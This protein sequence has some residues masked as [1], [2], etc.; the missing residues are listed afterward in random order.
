MIDRSFD[1]LY[2]QS[3]GFEN[4][5]IIFIDDCSTDNSREKIQYYSEKYENVIGIYLNENSGYA[6]KPRNEGLKC[7]T[8]EYVMFLD[9]DD[10]YLEDAC[11]T[12]YEKISSE[13]V[14]LAS[15]NFC[16][17]NESNIHS[18]NHLD[19]KDEIKINDITEKPSLLLLPP[20][21]WTKIYKRKFILENGISF[22][23][24]LPGQDALFLYD[25]FIHADGI[26]FINKALVVYC[27]RDYTQTKEK[28]ITDDRTYKRLYDYLIVYE[29]MYNI[30]NDFNEEMV[31]AVSS[32]FSYWSNL[33]KNSRIPSQEKI[34]LIHAF[35]IL[36]KKV[37]SN[38]SA[39][40]ELM[41]LLTPI[42]MTTITNILDIEN[43]DLE[44]KIL[45]DFDRIQTY[46]QKIIELNN[47][48]Y[49][50]KKKTQSTQ[51]EE[52]I[53]LEDSTNTLKDKIN[54]FKRNIF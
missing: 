23:E 39:D 37:N 1:S 3:I 17:D 4:L 52:E 16:L 2:N 40:N 35:R 10:Y 18:W 38:L 5:E 9:S 27:K 49:I 7:A 25:V 15:G 24:N 14:D 48:L 46:Q 33:L 11:E 41:T 31:I 44:N 8:S 53:A 21:I 28:S 51:I 45:N 43:K 6:G 32:H 54:L 22:D 30:L 47:K 19:I 50:E 29:K 42:Q 26:I 13:D 36:L 20:S 12:L 34:N